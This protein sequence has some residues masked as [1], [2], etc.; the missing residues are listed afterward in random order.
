VSESRFTGPLADLEYLV[1]RQDLRTGDLGVV[2]DTGYPAH[3]RTAAEQA[4]R[5]AA[6]TA[7]DHGQSVAHAVVRITDPDFVDP[8]PQSWL[9][10]SETSYGGTSWM[11]ESMSGASF[12]GLEDG[13]E[14]ADAA[15]AYFLRRRLGVLAPDIDD[16]QIDDDDWWR[17]SVWHA[18]RLDEA[19]HS[20]VGGRIADRA[21]LLATPEKLA[22]LG[23]IL[24][25]D[26]IPP[27]A[28]ATATPRQ[29]A[30]I[31][32]ETLSSRT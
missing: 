1:V 18:G 14:H 12:A 27:D 24:R 31:M 29:V 32:T 4:A 20:A 15:A 17:V 28:V 11:N 25:T 13:P 8:H 7:K 16:L 22:W 3:A 9:W 10:V 6:D 30:R 21:E 23:S 2:G 26:H 5:D 19:D